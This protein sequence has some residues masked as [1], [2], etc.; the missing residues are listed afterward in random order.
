MTERGI[1][2]EDL[3]KSHAYD[4]ICTLKEL[5]DIFYDSTYDTVKSDNFLLNT[6]NKIKIEKTAE[7]INIK[8]T[9]ENINKLI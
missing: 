5:K 6:T 1:L 9:N 4:D 2:L 3:N 7:K 8:M